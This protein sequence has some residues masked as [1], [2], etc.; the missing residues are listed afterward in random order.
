MYVGIDAGTSL[1]KAAA[2]DES[3][4][5]LAVE[6]ARA[7]LDL[8][9][10]RAEQDPEEIFT[11]VRDVAVAVRADR[12]AHI[13]VTGQGDGLWLLDGGGRPIRPAISWLDGRAADLVAE[14]TAS[15]VLEAVFRRTGNNN[16]TTMVPAFG[17]EIDNVVG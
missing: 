15:G 9:D 12:A 10:D 2:F 16:S 3:G 13:A 6:S 7:R 1:V 11:A 17:T 5:V 4:T 8:R 14:W